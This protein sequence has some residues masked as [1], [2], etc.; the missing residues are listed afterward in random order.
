[1]VSHAKHNQCCFLCFAQP[2]PEY[3]RVF[4]PITE[5]VQLWGLQGAS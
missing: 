1:M 5:A 3:H 2:N 4:Y